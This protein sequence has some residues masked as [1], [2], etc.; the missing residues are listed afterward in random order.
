MDVSPK[1]PYLDAY[2]CCVGWLIVLEE[3]YENEI[4]DLII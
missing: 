2:I 3:N 1:W 4:P